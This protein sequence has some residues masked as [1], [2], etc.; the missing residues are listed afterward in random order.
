MTSFERLSC[1]LQSALFHASPLATRRHSGQLHSGKSSFI[2]TRSVAAALSV[3]S[4]QTH[5]LWGDLDHVVG[6]QSASVRISIGEQST[7]EG[8]PFDRTANL[9]A[10]RLLGTHREKVVQYR[11]GLA[12]APQLK[13]P[14]R[15]P[16]RVSDQTTTI[17]RLFSL[18]DEA[19]RTHPLP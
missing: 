11:R 10:L 14:R 13:A 18:R 17:A 15:W 16:F 2:D 4:K 12:Q 5:R 8:F 1:G 7:D 3:G 9:S 6:K 19:E